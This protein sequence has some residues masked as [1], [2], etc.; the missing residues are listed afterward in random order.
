[1]GLG[2]GLALAKG[3]MEL[4]G[5]HLRVHSAG[6]GKGSEFM[7]CIPR[8]LISQS[9]TPHTAQPSG[10]PAKVL[11]RTILLADDNRDNADTMAMLLELSG[12]RVNVARNGAEAIQLAQELRP[13]IG[14]FDIGMPDMSGYAVAERIRREAWG[15]Q[16]ILIAVTGWGQESDKRK[17]LAAGFDHHLTKPVDPDKLTSLF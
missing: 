16:M 3:L 4:H 2:I 17:A 1:M 6:R 9:A 7:L 14:I 15:K 8:T 5:G 12:H 13:E 11:E 10:S